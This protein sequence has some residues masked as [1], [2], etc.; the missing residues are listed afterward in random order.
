MRQIRTRSATNVWIA[1]FVGA[2]ALHLLRGKEFAAMTRWG[3]NAGWQREVAIWNFGMTAALLHTRRHR[4][5]S[6]ADFLTAF[7]LMGTLLAANHLAA[8]V[9]SPGSAAHWLGLAAN[10]FG[11]VTARLS[12][13]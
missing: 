11:T 2:A 10:L 7:T 6:D 9:R 1:G 3:P 12:R 13:N 4:R 8:A 5:E